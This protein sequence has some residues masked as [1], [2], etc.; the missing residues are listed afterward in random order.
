MIA[1]LYVTTVPGAAPCRN[2]AGVLA[3]D[4]VE[5]VFHAVPATQGKGPYDSLDGQ[6]KDYPLTKVHVVVT[7]Q[8]GSD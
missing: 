7:S 1:G 3:L 5:I 2:P 6:V 8:H 4:E